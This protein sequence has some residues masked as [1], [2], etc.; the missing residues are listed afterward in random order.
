MRSGLIFL[1]FAG[2]SLLPW[3]AAQ[4]KLPDAIY[5]EGQKAGFAFYKLSHR[6]P[7][8]RAWATGDGAG[9]QA[10]ILREGFREYDPGPRT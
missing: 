1:A 4:A 5:S 7:D 3:P 8:F 6:Q 9:N 2:L 10:E